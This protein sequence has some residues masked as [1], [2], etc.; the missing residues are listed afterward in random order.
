M[1]LCD[2]R[3][4]GTGG[5]VGSRRRDTGLCARGH[6]CVSMNVHRP[7][8]EGMKTSLGGQGGPRRGHTGPAEGRWALRAGAPGLPSLK[9]TTGWR[10]RL[11]P[12]PLS[13]HPPPHLPQLLPVLMEGKNFS[14]FLLYFSRRVTRSGKELPP[15]QTII[16]PIYRSRRYRPTLSCWGSHSYFWVLYGGGTPGEVIW[17]VLSCLLPVHIPPSQIPPHPLPVLPA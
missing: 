3:M 2:V 17:G 11:S 16:K 4:R 14:F 5:G 8:R 1:C 13:S 15:P 10:V 6:L 12:H 9:T 7:G